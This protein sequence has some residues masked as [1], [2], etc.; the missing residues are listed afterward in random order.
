MPFVSSRE[1]EEFTSIIKDLL[2]QADEL[3]K[4][5][6]NLNKEKI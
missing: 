1:V 2:L 6:S 4:V 5:V 3:E